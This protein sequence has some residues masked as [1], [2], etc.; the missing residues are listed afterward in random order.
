MNDL[1]ES[2]SALQRCQAFINCQLRPAAQPALREERPHWRAVTVSRQAGA[3]GHTVAEQLARYLQTH[4]PAGA[5]PWTVFDPEDR[6]SEI[7]DALDDLLGVHPP[8]ETLIRQTAETILHLVELGNVILVGRGANVVTRRMRDVF[9]VRLIGSLEER[10]EHIQKLRQIGRKAA[11]EFIRVEDRGRRRYLKKYF[12]RDIDDPLLYHLVINTD[13]VGY[14]NAA[15]LIGNTVLGSARVV[16][17]A[18]PN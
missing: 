12:G 6:V 3:G 8:A 15:A 17:V 7:E 18:H 4:S 2:E 16:S 11:L 10:V 5:S 9:H 14:E 13:L 1:M